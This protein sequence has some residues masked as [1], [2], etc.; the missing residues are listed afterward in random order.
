MDNSQSFNNIYLLYQK[1]NY[2]RLSTIAL[3]VINFEIT[4]E[5]ADEFLTVAI[6]RQLVIQEKNRTLSEIQSILSKYQQ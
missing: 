5:V 3:L 4:T 2:D 6:K 1:N